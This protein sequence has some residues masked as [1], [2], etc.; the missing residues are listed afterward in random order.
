MREQ[1]ENSLF[2]HTHTHTLWICIY[3]RLYI[4]GC[5]VRMRNICIDK[6]ITYTPALPHRIWEATIALSL[7]LS[8]HARAVQL[9]LYRYPISGMRAAFLSL[10]LSNCA[11]ALSPCLRTLPEK[12]TLY[13]AI[14]NWSCRDRTTCW[15]CILD[16]QMGQ[17]CVYM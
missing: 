8:C 16:R 11:V 17:L 3:T 5:T 14:D 6:H 7:S 9:D 13:S 15:T 12:L 2:L 4:V 1:H 10:S